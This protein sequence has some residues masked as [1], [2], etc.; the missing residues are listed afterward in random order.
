MLAHGVEEAAHRLLALEWAGFNSLK[1]SRVVSREIVAEFDVDPSL[2]R[3]RVVDFFRLFS[4]TRFSTAAAWFVNTIKVMWR[5]QTGVALC[6][7][8][9]MTRQVLNSAVFLE[10]PYEHMLYRINPF[11]PS[12]NISFWMYSS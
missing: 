9:H 2:T 1:G 6:Q 12:T 5:L 11:S 8:C 10:L 7:R 4:I 3:P